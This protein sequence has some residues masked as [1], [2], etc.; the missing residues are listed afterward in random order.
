MTVGAGEGSIV[1]TRFGRVAMG[2]FRVRKTIKIAPGL[3]INLGKTG[4][5]LS[6]GKPGATVNFGRRGPR[7]TVGLPGT[8]LSY[9]VALG[10][11][12][13]SPRA[14]SGAAAPPVPAR[15]VMVGLMELVYGSLFLAGLILLF[16]PGYWS[17]GLGLL[18]L[19]LLASVGIALAMQPGRHDGD[20]ARAL[21]S[22]L[23]DKPPPGPPV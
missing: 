7:A 16:V 15:T 9:S 6:V 12:A 8:G 21:A 4:A 3:K 23:F 22:D 5:S 14:L 13:R 2:F 18:A 20:E 11:R 10:K 17:L 19:F 1:D